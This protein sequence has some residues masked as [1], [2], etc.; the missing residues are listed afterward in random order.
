MLIQVQLLTPEGELVESLPVYNPSVDNPFLIKSIE[1]LGPAPTTISAQ[2]FAF[3]DGAGLTAT[4]TESRNIIF[5]VGYRPRPRLGEDVQV[6]RRRLYK[7]FRAKTS[8]RMRFISDN[9]PTVDI[10]GIVES[11]EPMIFASEPSVQ[12]S[13]LC[14]RPYFRDAITRTYD[15]LINGSREYITIQNEGDLDVGVEYEITYTTRV[16]STLPVNT[17][18]LEHVEPNGAT[19][20]TV[21]SNQVIQDMTGSTFRPLDRIVFTSI[22]GNKGLFLYRDIAKINIMKALTNNANPVH[23]AQ[24]TERP[25]KFRFV[26]TDPVTNAERMTGVVRY[27]P[28]YEGL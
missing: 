22:Q 5:S 9:M 26:Y 19:H 3:Q 18:T 23:W 25:S 4:R 28:I 21:I 10:D 27:T 13:V 11:H 6:L 2:N 1:G 7:L 17:L 20:Q 15:L 12:I 16:G 14:L 8:I 24:L